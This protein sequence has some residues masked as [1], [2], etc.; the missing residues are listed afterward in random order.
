MTKVIAKTIN[1]AHD[2]RLHI[3]YVLVA[4]CLFLIGLYCF[5]VYTIIS[6][7]SAISHAKSQIAIIEN[8]LKDLDAEYLKITGNIKA[9]NLKDF[10][11][12]EGKVTV[13]IDR[14]NFSPVAYDH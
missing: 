11:M 10:G 4:S 2:Y 14:N 13:F 1:T 5:N 12:K 7:T 3:S 9:D 8:L 6:N